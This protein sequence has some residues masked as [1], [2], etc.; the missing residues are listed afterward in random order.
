MHDSSIPDRHIYSHWPFMMSGLA[1]D[2]RAPWQHPLYKGAV[3]GYTRDQCPQSLSYLGRAVMFF[4]DQ[5]FTD[6]DADL[7]VEGVWKVSRALLR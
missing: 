4:I 5:F 7:L 3:S 1:E 6:E 2:R